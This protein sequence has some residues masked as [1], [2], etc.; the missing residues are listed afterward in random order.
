MN[1]VLQ[2]LAGMAVPEGTTQPGWIGEAP[3]QADEVL[4]ARNGLVHLPSF[5]GGKDYSR[6]PTPRFF[7]PNAL[8][9]DFDADAGSRRNGWRS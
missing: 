8:D 9:Y 6:E 3:F 2:A 1:N 4:A 5:V 7:S